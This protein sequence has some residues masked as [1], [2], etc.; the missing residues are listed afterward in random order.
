[1]ASREGTKKGVYFIVYMSVLI[2]DVFEAFQFSPKTTGWMT[3]CYPLH[4]AL[5]ALLGVS[6]VADPT[7][8]RMP[9]NSGF[10]HF[11]SGTT[12]YQ[13]AD[14]A[15]NYAS[16]HDRPVCLRKGR[17]RDFVFNLLLPSRKEAFDCGPLYAAEAFQ[18]PTAL[19]G[20][21]SPPTITPT[22]SAAALL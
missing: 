15:P 22:Q 10:E 7:D 16:T 11:S 18:C 3:L 14:R 8:L 17:G 19:T 1:M 12:A 6:A 2:F 13:K 21:R 5:L 9:R 4:G 20:I